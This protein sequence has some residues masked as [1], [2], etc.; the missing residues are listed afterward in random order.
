MRRAISP[1]CRRG[2]H[3]ALRG[4]AT[5]VTTHLCQLCSSV[6]RAG[7]AS[8]CARLGGRARS[9]SSPWRPAASPRSTAAQ[10]SRTD[11]G[12]GCRHWLCHRRCRYAAG[13]PLQPARRLSSADMMPGL[14]AMP[15]STAAASAV[16]AVAA[17][18]RQLEGRARQRVTHRAPAAV[19]ALVPARPAAA[20]RMAVAAPQW[21][22][23]A[24]QKQHKAAS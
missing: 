14:K 3:P 15:P 11:G 12:L 6:A 8:P 5:A 7:L 2:L 18:P 22:T 23:A 16:A 13:A 19:E 24:W 1:C 17:E 21:A 9:C 4:S 10:V 20:M